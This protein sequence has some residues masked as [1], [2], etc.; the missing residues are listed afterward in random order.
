MRPAGSESPLY[1]RDV[2]TWAAEQTDILARLEAGGIGPEVDWRH[3]IEVIDEIARSEVR[4]VSDAVLAVLGSA[5]KGFIDPDSPVR[6]RW[7][8][9]SL[10]AGFTIRDCAVASVRSRLDL[11]GVW[12]EAF[13]AA[14]P[15]V[16]P[17]LICGV[18]P[19]LP[20]TCPFGRDDLLDEAFTYE[21]AVRRLY[22]NLM[23]PSESTDR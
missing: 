19:G 1:D 12:S 8:L 2:L 4:I 22:D 18:P 21:L 20:R 17:D 10:D 9:A 23:V 14:L 3:V 16:G 15:E 11:D 5:I 6:L 7:R 13:D